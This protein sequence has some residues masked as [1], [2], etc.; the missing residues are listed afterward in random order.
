MTSRRVTLYLRGLLRVNSESQNH[1]DLNCLIA[2]ERR[3]KFPIGQGCQNFRLKF[4]RLRPYDTWVPDNPIA[5]EH[6]PDNQVRALQIG[7]KFRAHG[8]GR[9]QVFRIGLGR[10]SG[11]GKLHDDS[12]NRRR[13]VDGVHTIAFECAV[14]VQSA[15]RPGAGDYG[16]SIAGFSGNIGAASSCWLRSRAKTGKGHNVV[17]TGNRNPR[18]SWATVAEVSRASRTGNRRAASVIESCG[19]FSGVG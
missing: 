12:S 3:R 13:Y 7:G 1:V 17:S 15:S 19:A 8:G 6:A 18:H 10:R 9:G 11:I 16:D 4:G 2:T 14:K 5:I